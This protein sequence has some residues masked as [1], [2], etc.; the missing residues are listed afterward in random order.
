MRKNLV[1][2]FGLH[3]IAV[4]I[5]LKNVKSTGQQATPKAASKTT[6]AKKRK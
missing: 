6:L 3:G 2:E 5:I 1:E 4:R